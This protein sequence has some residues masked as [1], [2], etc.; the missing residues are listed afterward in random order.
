MEF[1]D[2]QSI[3]LQIVD[4]VVD[5][6]LKG[7]Y[8]EGERIPSVRE[9]AIDTEVNPNTVVRSYAEL[10]DREIIHNRR[11]IGYFVSEGAKERIR[12]EKTRQLLQEEVPRLVALIRTVGMSAAELA[13]AI[14]TYEEEHRT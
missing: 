1:D 11:G 13:D 4:Y 5:G 14:K 2:R 10:Q 7:D 8:R 9:L 3:Y 6:I 12:R